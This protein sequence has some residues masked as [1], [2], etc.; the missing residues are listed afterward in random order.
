MLHNPIDES[1]SLIADTL[2]RDYCNRYIDLYPKG[3]VIFDDGT[4]VATSLAQDPKY[5]GLYQSQLVKR[6]ARILN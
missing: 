1:L 4:V 6:K 2:K 3:N 5:L